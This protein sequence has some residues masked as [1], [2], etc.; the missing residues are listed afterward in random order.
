MNAEPPSPHVTARRTANRLAMTQI[1]H[2][3]DVFVSQ[4]HRRFGRK[5]PSTPNRSRT[6]EL[7]VTS[8]PLPLSVRRVT[9]RFDKKSFRYK[10]FQSSCKIIV[11]C[12]WLKER[13]IFS[14]NVFLV[15]APTIL[16][17]RNFCAIALLEFVLKRLVSK[18]PVSFRRLMGVTER[19]V[20]RGFNSWF[21][22]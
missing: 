16:S 10:L 5:I 9:G 21:S 20:H 7:L 8:L 18:R 4:W 22:F 11:P 14:Q 15:H 2:E 13:R 19:W 17:D 12:T 1:F 3:K 6:C